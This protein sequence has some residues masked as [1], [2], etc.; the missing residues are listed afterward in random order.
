MDAQTVFKA[1]ADTTRRRILQLVAGHELSVSE[2]VDCLSQPQSTVSRHL[3]VLRDAELIDD[4][5]EGVAVL[6]AAS[7]RS[8]AGQGD[9][10]SLQTRMLD[11]VECEPLPAA[12]RRRLDG[13]LSRRRKRS[14]DF[15]ARI[16]R[17]W[18]RMRVEAFGDAFH[19]EALAALLPHDW[20]VADIGTGT[21]YLL[22]VLGATFRKV[23]AV[24][25]VPR[26]LDVARA[27]CQ[28]R[29][30][31][32]VMF[33]QGDLSRLPIQ[34]ERVDLACAMLV[35][36]HVPAPAEALGEL[37][38]ILKPGGR[39]VIVEQKAHKLGAFYE[40]MQ[41]RWWG[42]DPARL[43]R[44]VAATGLEEVRYRDL[45]FEPVP[46]AAVEAPDLFVLDARR[47][48]QRARPVGKTKGNR[49]AAFPKTS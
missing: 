4:R 20:V 10:A 19:L 34:D 45:S 46:V 39:L 6:Y 17:R 3:K 25:P 14:T 28:S 1:M 21:G 49:K 12:L 18:D 47:K 38:R 9:D 7:G 37:A 22:P 44:D 15:F 16:G 13:V 23:F 27:R 40:R 2:L 29:R 24:D 8:S 43:A 26:M 48:A 11:W 35:L 33:R 31:K 41:D 5:R 32:N 30:T 36:H 42:F